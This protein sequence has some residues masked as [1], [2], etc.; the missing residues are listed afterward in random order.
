MSA[1]LTL[2]GRSRITKLTEPGVCY[3]Y[4][5]I[6]GDRIKIG[7]TKRLAWR[8]MELRATLLSF[9]EGGYERE[10]ELQAQFVEHRIGERGEWFTLAEEIMEYAAGVRARLGQEIME[11]APD[12]RK[13]VGAGIA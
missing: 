5:A 6:S 7:S 13:R 1:P 4:V 11:P 2:R 10:R 9:E 12:T 3:V 8:M